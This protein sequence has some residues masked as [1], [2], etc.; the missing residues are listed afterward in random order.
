MRLRAEEWA[1]GATVWLLDVVAPDRQQ[2]TLVLAI[3]RKLSGGR[4]VKIAPLVARL[5]DPEVAAKLR[6]A[7]GVK[8]S[9]QQ[10]G[11]GNVSRAAGAPIVHAL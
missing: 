5:I 6:G 4:A 7:S 8:G 9:G 11:S 10:C 3:F 2:A 1:S